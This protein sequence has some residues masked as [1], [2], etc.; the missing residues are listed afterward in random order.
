[1]T[2]EAETFKKSNAHSPSTY[3]EEDTT[4]RKR[5]ERTGREGMKE[6][7][8]SRFEKG[9]TKRGEAMRTSRIF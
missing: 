5:R 1:M 2:W 9:R 7:Q 6:L 8:G 3:G 4:T